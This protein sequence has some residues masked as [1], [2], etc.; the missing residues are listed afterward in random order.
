MR[1][2]VSI[3]SI[4]LLL[5]ACKTQ[6]TTDKKMSKTFNRDEMPAPGP[7]PK[8]EFKQ[9]KSFTLSNGMKVMVVENHKLP[10]VSVRL[11]LDNPPIL[12]KDRRGMVSLFGRMMG[13]GTKKYPKDVFN[14]KI[15]FTGASVSFWSSGASM[16]SLTKFFPE[17]FQLMADGITH[18]VF[19]QV[20]FNKQ[21]DKL[22]DELKN[23]EKS[24][25]AIASR[26]ENVLAF[27]L[28]HP[29]GEFTDIET[30][31]RVTLSDI[32]QLYEFRY[33]PDNAYLII[34]GDVDYE[35]VKTLVK[36]ELSGWKKGNVTGV[37][38]PETH[39]PG[40]PEIDFV[41]MPDAA[42]S[43]VHIVATVPFDMKS[44]DYFAALVAN[45]IFGGDFNSHLNMNLRE[46]HG[47]TYGAR[48]SIRPDKYISKFRAGAAV[49]HEVADSTIVEIMK[50]LHRIRTEK[51]TEDELNTVKAAFTGE[52]VRNIEKPETVARLA[53]NIEKY[54][55]PKDFYKTYLEKINS[56]TAD[57]VLK[58][59]QKYFYPNPRIVMVSKGAEVV[60][61]L[62]KLDY[63]VKYYDT[64]GKPTSKPK[65]KQAAE[66]N[67]T[68]QIVWD[69]YL[70]ARGG[71]EKLENVHSLIKV[72]EEHM[73]PML[74][75]STSKMKSPNKM[76]IIREMQ[77]RKML[78]KFNGEQGYM[79]KMGSKQMIPP[80]EVAKM[81]ARNG[82][83]GDIL[84]TENMEMSLEGIEPVN[85]K[86]TYKVKTVQNGEE[87]YF[88]FDKATGLLL[89]EEEKAI[90]PQDGKEMIIP[91]YYSDYRDVDGIKIPFKKSSVMMGQEV[92]GEIKEIQINPVIDD[93]EFE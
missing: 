32:K 54:G 9:P 72:E 48:S 41:D 69:K 89:K 67:M 57:D 23:N 35:E 17:I 50:E 49:R 20:E 44:Q 42:Q 70:Q 79:E 85:G 73:G 52:F 18:P 47:F 22:K 82:I 77:G 64:K 78:I 46:K 83:F 25:P 55:L 27:G 90:N 28:N 51:V 63:E 5:A 16:H 21:K 26:V 31:D 75:K 66:K 87:K 34:I 8:V 7:A 39:N 88:Y 30:L 29:Y 45:K 6:Q 19:T 68:A 15:D 61:A 38:M 14:E 92:Q 43:E 10:R 80:A 76:L 53:V 4:V 36:N 58:A 74:S 3:L 84:H 1:T 37:R 71:R 91:V 60:P 2:I 12:E 40:K 33:R 65:V 13:T 81:K 62:E 24:V 93:S 56:V 59:A 11:S 86:D